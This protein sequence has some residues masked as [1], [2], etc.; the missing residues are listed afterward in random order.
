MR[1]SFPSRP[2]V[3]R[4][5]TMWTT[6]RRDAPSKPTVAARRVPGATLRGRAAERLIVGRTRAVVGMLDENDV[7]V[8]WP[9]LD[10]LVLSGQELEFVQRVQEA[11]SCS[12]DEAHDLLARRYDSLRRSRPRDFTCAR[13]VLAQLSLVKRRPRGSDPLAP[14]SAVDVVRQWRTIGR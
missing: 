11:T 5:S 10:R 6:T 1:E 9:S 14:R 7:R 8:D 4:I 3:R 13:G 12:L 2:H